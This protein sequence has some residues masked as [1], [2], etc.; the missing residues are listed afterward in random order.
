MRT[1]GCLVVLFIGLALG[2]LLRD[3]IP[4]AGRHGRSGAR[5]ESVWQ[6]ISAAGAARTKA[7]LE[8]MAQPQGSAFETLRA[9]DVASYVFTQLAK[10]L[11]PSIDSVEAAAIADR[12]FV[13]GVLKPAELGVASALGPLAAM[14]GE[15]EH[16]QFGGDF[17]ILRPGLAE[18]RVREVRVHDFAIPDPLIPRVLRQSERGSRPTGVDENA[19]PLLV[20]TFLGDVRVTANRVTLYKRAP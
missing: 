6:P 19:L 13:R 4:S 10:Q 2:W 11:P 7:A 16:A 12:L 15:R 5:S 18:F 3:V 9:A 17:H 8:R 20:P 1:I 14:L